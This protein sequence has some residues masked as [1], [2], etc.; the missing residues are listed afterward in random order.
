MK[1]MAEFDPHLNRGDR[2]GVALVLGLATGLDRE[3]KPHNKRAAVNA[4]ALRQN[5]GSRTFR[6]AMTGLTAP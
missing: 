6:I 2:F 4:A 5:K 3:A 1:D